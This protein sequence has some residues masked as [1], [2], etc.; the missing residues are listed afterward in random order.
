LL[1][2]IVIAAGVKL[3]GTVHTSVATTG[4]LNFDG[5][6]LVDLRVELPQ[7]KT[8]FIDM[9]RVPFI[10]TLALFFTKIFF[11]CNGFQSGDFLLSFE[12]RPFLLSL[13]LFLLNS[14]EKVQT[15]RIR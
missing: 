13:V 7:D 4:H 15:R 12:I 6:K 11:C 1:D 3:T 9:K 2:W 5:W 14:T 8:E 10:L